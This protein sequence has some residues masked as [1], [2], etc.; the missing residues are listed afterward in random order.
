MILSVCLPLWGLF[1]III[2]SI[3]FGFV[4]CAFLAAASDKE[5][6]EISRRGSEPDVWAAH[7][8]MR[9]HSEQEDY[10]DRRL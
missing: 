9:E 6:E 8:H 5:D 1:A 10:M 2:A 7:N 4:I 3:V